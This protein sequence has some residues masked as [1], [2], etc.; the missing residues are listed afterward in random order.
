M[1]HPPCLRCCPPPLPPWEW[2]ACWDWTAHD[3]IVPFFVTPCVIGQWRRPTH[4]TVVAA[5]SRRLIYNA[6]HGMKRSLSQNKIWLPGGKLLHLKAM[7]S[8][9][10]LPHN[11]PEKEREGQVM[12]HA[13][14]LENEAGCSPAVFLTFCKT[15]V[16]SWEIEVFELLHCHLIFQNRYFHQGAEADRC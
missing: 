13:T 11:V 12:T 8:F 10:A 7:L 2:Q 3:Q 1:A 4:F 5:S 15:Q 16:R 9:L 14:G 6:S